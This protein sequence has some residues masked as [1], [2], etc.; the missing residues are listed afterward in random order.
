MLATDDYTQLVS[1]RIFDFVNRHAPWHLALWSVGTALAMEETCEYGEQFHAGQSNDKG[2]RYVAESTNSLVTVDA[3]VGSE[4]LRLAIQQALDFKAIATAS[5]LATLKHLTDRLRDG[6]VARLAVAARSQQQ[7]GVEALST[8]ATAHLLDVGFSNGFLHAWLSALAK[9]DTRTFDI[10][11]VLDEAASLCKA[12][13]EEY[14]VVVPFEAMPQSFEGAMPPGWLDSH[15][16]AEL[17]ATFDPAPG[18]ENLRQAGS[19]VLTVSARD[20]WSAAESAAETVAQAAARV[21][22]SSA[23]SRLRPKG[24]AW[25]RGRAGNFPLRSRTRVQLKSLKTADQV[26]RLSTDPGDATVFDALEIFAGLDSGTRGA[27]LTGGWAAVEALLLRSGEAPHTVAA[28]RLAA[29]TAC[30][31]PR[32]E[33]T[34]LS[35]RHAPQTADALSG[36]LEGV[37]VNV[38][39]CRI[40]EQALRSGHPVAV[41]R[42]SDR[43]M[44]RRIEGMI[45]DPA[46]KLHN[47]ERYVSET[48][49]RLYTQRNLIMHA[50]SFRSVTLR[51][52]LRTAP[53]LVAAGVDRIVDAYTAPGRTEPVALAAR[54]EVEL[55]LLGSPA[56]RRL[57]DLLD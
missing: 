15:A 7:P 28:D 37:E 54:A 30:A 26:F 36:A 45:A 41:T 31:F 13:P 19:V 32:A 18:G 35:Y 12:A 22:V 17:M 10:G 11:D 2:L 6:Y 57:S 29:I 48:F 25:V 55:R 20:P 21:A 4:E 33:L 40:L 47:V 49:R 16:T 56:E 42:P 1:A 23:R 34:A 39:R 24:H 43:A 52:T 38:E 50:G 46:T 51:A 27:E 9:D 5:G 53:R 44:L 8:A 14:Q 3:G